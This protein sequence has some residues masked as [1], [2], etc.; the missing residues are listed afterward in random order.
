[1]IVMWR[2]KK[3]HPQIPEIRGSRISDA[4]IEG[5][6]ATGTPRLLFFNQ[7]ILFTVEPVKHTGTIPFLSIMLHWKNDIAPIES[8]SFKYSHHVPLNN[9]GRKSN[10]LYK[11]S[12]FFASNLWHSPEFWNPTSVLGC[13]LPTK[14]EKNPSWR[15]RVI[16][17]NRKYSPE[18]SSDPSPERRARVFFSLAAG[19]LLTPTH[20]KK[21]RVFGWS[22]WRKQVE[23]GKKNRQHKKKASHGIWT[24]SLR[25]NNWHELKPCP[26]QL[27]S[28]Q[29]DKLK[30]WKL[31]RWENSSSQTWFKLHPHLSLVSLVN[32]LLL[33]F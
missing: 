24:E 1:M 17:W 2:K 11:S 16:L 3:T 12:C 33:I 14:K 6:L 27:K 30:S 26:V 5:N 10:S 9:D 4:T 22:R 21:L 32:F 28:L 8:L 18:Y 23:G 25:E 13:F 7:I 19:F 31:K 15:G 20:P 29:C